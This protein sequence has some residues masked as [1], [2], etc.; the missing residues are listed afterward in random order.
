MRF[1]WLTITNMFLCFNFRYLDDNSSV[2]AISTKLRDVCPTLFLIEDAACAKVY[3]FYYI[4]IYFIQ[5]SYN[6]K[7]ML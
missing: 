2:D 4:E 7:T 5:D 3:P 1:P 6:G